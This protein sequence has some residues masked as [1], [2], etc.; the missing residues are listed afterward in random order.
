MRSLLVLL[1]TLVGTA[2]AVP[3]DDPSSLTFE[4]RI[5]PLLKTHCFQ[6]HGE[7]H[8]GKPKGKLDVRLRHLLVKGGRSGPA[9]VA[10]R[11]GESLLY[12]NLVKGEMPPEDVTKRP[13]KQEIELIGR[14]IDLGAVTAREEPETPAAGPTAEELAFWSFRPV[15]SVE[16]PAV[17]GRAR[18]PIDRFLLAALAPKG[19]G[20]SPDAD[21]ITLIRRATFTLTGLPPR[22]DDVAA[23]LADEAPDAYERLVDRLL[24]STAYGE[25]WGRHWLDVAGY[26]DSEGYDERDAER[27]WAWRFRDY[28]IRSFNADKPFDRFLQEQIAGDELLKPPYTNLKPDEIDTLVATG[29]LRMGPDGTGSPNA[30]QVVA[31]NQVVGDTIKIVSTGVLGLTV[32]CAQCHNHRYDP[33]TQVDYYRMRAVFEPAYAG[34]EWRT[35]AQRLVSLYT[36][37][38]RKKAAEIEAQAVAVDRE[39]E[40]KQ[41]EFIAATI[42]KELAKVPDEYREALRWVA[43]TP[44]KERST[45]QKE[46]LKEHPSVNVSASSLYL[47]NQKAADELKKIAD[48]AAQIRGTKPAEE[49]LHVL[50]EVPGK[51]PETRLFHRGDPAQ[52]KQVVPPGTLSVLGAAPIAP[53]DPSLPTSGRR[54]AFAKWLTDGNHPLT[55]RVLVNRMWMHHF[56]R[57][58]V[59]TPGDFGA[60]GERPS[61]PE[62]L[63]WLAAEVVRQGWRLKPIH[64]MILTSTAYRQSS[65]RTAKGE[66]ADPDNRLLWRMN[67]HRMEAESIRDSMLAVAGNLNAK[68]FGPPVPVMA[69][70]V[71]QIVVGRENLD[72]EGKVDKPIPLN[73]DE[74]RR[75]LYVQVR[76]SKILSMLECFDVPVMEPNCEARSFST[77]APQALL[78]MNNTFVLAQSEQFAKR[79]RTHAGDDAA[80]RVALAWKLAFSRSPSEHEVKDGVAFL[81]KMAS[82]KKD[83]ALTRFCQALLS[84]NEFLYVD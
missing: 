41:A 60:L 5:R 18:T 26:A 21:K 36:D 31:R 55:A 32:G 64:R 75:S 14:W 57:G 69:D 56:G 45:L 22:P 82:D 80:A 70:E 71:G 12:Q 67:I 63:D 34:G 40:Q 8:D 3:D 1:V 30:E 43:T 16:P 17:D 19:L 11:R 6:C 78:L 44:A 77:V 84:S 58:I 42:E 9:I 49:Y 74:F 54:L 38:D 29:F 46:L 47:Y 73:G 7:Q 28:V 72:G 61:H 23:F 33:I 24:A 27:K 52:P 10:G 81:N 48:R 65:R 13:T 83:A 79:V 20:F 15:R 50:T 53:R 25:R 39:R 2:S 59:G 4:A 35:P 76:R 68:M 62:L 66:A 37:A 51:L